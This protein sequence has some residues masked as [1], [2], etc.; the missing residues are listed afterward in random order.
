[1]SNLLLKMNWRYAT[2]IFDADKK[3]SDEDFFTLTEIL[4]LS[5]SSFGLQPWKFLIIENKKIREE[6]VV[7]SWGQR[8][9][10]DASH[11]IVLCRKTNLDEKFIEAH[12]ENIS[13]IRK[14]DITSLNPYK[15]R[16]G[17]FI[18]NLT[19]DQ[20]SN[21]ANKQLYIALGTLL[22]SAAEMKIDACP[23]EGFIAKEYD[24]ILELHNFGLTAS[25]VCP[26]G[27]RAQN[28]K[29][30]SAPKVRY[31]REDVFIKI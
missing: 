31:P 24:R 12:L 7:H 13:K 20:M 28:D 14:V 26:L 27:Y 11:L 23:I 25:V 10:A 9:V 8:Q 2:K 22:T 21:W 3:I 5:P 15:E 18:K 4:R 6:L 1:M 30:A 17:G 19:P 16:I 29:Y